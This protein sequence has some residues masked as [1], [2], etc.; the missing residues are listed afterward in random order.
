MFVYPL[1]CGVHAICIPLFA[2]LLVA[3]LRLRERGR[4]SE[5]RQCGHSFYRTKYAVCLECGQPH[6][7]PISIGREPLFWCAIVA[8]APPIALDVMIILVVVLNL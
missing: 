5:C 4:R 1:C 7:P 2:F 6:E 3:V 8:I